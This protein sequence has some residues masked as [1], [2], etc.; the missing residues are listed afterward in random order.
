MYKR[1]VPWQGP[2]ES[3]A[4]F[5]ALHE[6]RYGYSLTSSVELVNIC[7]DVREVYEPIQLP[8]E[9]AMDVQPARLN[10]QDLASEADD[11]PAFHREALAFG[12]QLSGPCVITEYS[13]T[14]YVAEHWL[15]E[16]DALGNLRLSRKQ[17]YE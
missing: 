2:A 10:G 13:A 15:A 4:A 17:S 14:V 7:V 12:Q 6:R 1:Q 9:T 3:L 11:V 8:S 16:I 5:R